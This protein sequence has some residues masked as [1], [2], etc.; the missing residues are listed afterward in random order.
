MGGY[1]TLLNEIYIVVRNIIIHIVDGY[2]DL[3]LKST[4]FV[5]YHYVAIMGGYGALLNEIYIGCR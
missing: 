5:V 2:I 4:I 1:G 3:F